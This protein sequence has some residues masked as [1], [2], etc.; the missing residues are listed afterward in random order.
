MIA[1]KILRL[2]IFIRPVV[3]GG[4][5]EKEVY[6]FLLNVKSVIL[7]G[8]FTLIHRHLRKRRYQ[9]NNPL[10][11]FDSMFRYMI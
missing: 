3:I 4:K 7:H 8:Y 5:L 1:V 9:I 2:K 10:R 6:N 11:L